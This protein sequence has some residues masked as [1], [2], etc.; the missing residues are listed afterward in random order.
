MSDG[1]RAEVPRNCA[2]RR[3]ALAFLALATA[4]LGVAV[5]SGRKLWA[6]LAY[7]AG[8]GEA[9][10]RPDTDLPGRLEWYELAAARDPSDPVY[11]L[12]AGQIL[13]SRFSRVAPAERAATLDAASRAIER[14]RALSPLDP[15]TQVLLA[16]IAQARGDVVIAR[17]RAD[18]AAR[19]GPRHPGALAVAVRVHL[20]AFARARDPEA[21]A[22][23]LEIAADAQETVDHP[24]PGSDVA[25]T[26]PAAAVVRAALASGELTLD[27]VLFSVPGSVTLLTFVARVA[28]TDPDSQARLRAAIATL[29]GTLAPATE[30]R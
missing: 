15:R 11:S 26:A 21:L 8:L 6:E 20:W 25:S 27:D 30:P 14:A 28:P 22:R 1:A 4:T 12:R 17:D 13:L 9:S 24:A 10:E 19:L 2:P 3:A 16:Q 5:I 7:D 18:A 23:A 29:G